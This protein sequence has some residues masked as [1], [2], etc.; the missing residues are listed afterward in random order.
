[1]Y[2]DLRI[3]SDDRL[4][5]DDLR[6]DRNGACLCRPNLHVYESL[7]DTSRISDITNNR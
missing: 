5:R 1:V 3:L 7:T 2:V 4:T 6:S